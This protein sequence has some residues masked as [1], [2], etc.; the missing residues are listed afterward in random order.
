MA[1]RGF[2]AVALA[3]ASIAGPV[4]PGAAPERPAAVSTLPERLTDQEFWR[5]IT[6]VSEPNGYFQSDNFLSNEMQFQSVIPE[7]TRRIAPDTV[8]LGV[9][10][11]QNFSYI[12]ALQ[13][14]LAFIVDIRRQNLLEHLI[15]KA[16]LE[17]SADRA[18]FLS[19][20]FSR[21]IAPVGARASPKELFEASLNSPK[22]PAFYA[23]NL[24]AIVDL[25]TKTHG[26]TLSADDLDQMAYVY[27]TFYS[28]GP[29]L[30][31]ST[32]GPAR[33]GTGQMP[34]YVELMLTTDVSGVNRSYL[35][36]EANF[37]A[38]KAFERDNRLIPIVGDFAGNTA[39]RTVAQYL[40]A[41][42]A[43][44][45][46]FYTSNVEQYLFQDPDHWMKFYANVAALPQDPT[47]TF[48]R[49]CFQGCVGGGRGGPF[50]RGG[51]RFGP[52]GPNG[53]GFGAAAGPLASQSLLEMF[54]DLLGA[55]K[56]GKIH[57]Y[58]DVIARSR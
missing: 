24:H 45:T 38:L 46:V 5:L 27:G 29:G 23:S 35:A 4:V 11:E 12:V 3:L 47:S 13:P 22:D 14:R 1:V 16:A 25:L 37:A 52:Q 50:G 10:P 17:L 26:F 20:L 15:Y 7:L 42:G 6:D 48:I 56:E 41:H 9:G 39:L 36:S 30:Q 57:G 55:L 32:G 31:Y 34:N 43:V 58:Y 2:I 18:A 40:S 53:A 21:H 51:R 54:S 44:A 49:S 33:R 19:V 28:A 8:Y